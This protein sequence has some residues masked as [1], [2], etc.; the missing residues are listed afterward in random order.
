MIK[1]NVPSWVRSWLSEICV[2]LPVS[3]AVSLLLASTSWAVV[4]N[5]GDLVVTATNDE[6]GDVTMDGELDILSGKIYLG[7]LE[8]VGGDPGIEITYSD[9]IGSPSTFT[10]QAKSSPNVWLWKQ[11]PNS[12][13]KQ[14]SLDDSNTLRLFTGGAGDEVPGVTISPSTGILL[15]GAD[16]GITLHDSTQIHS[17][18]SLRQSAL[19]ATPES[20]PVV[21]VGSDGLTFAGGGALNS[22]NVTYLQRLLTNLGYAGSRI[23]GV[24][25][26]ISVP[27]NVAIA[28]GTLDAVGNIYLCGNFSVPVPALGL[29]NPG[30]SDAFVAKLS[31][32]GALLWSRT[33]TGVGSDSARAVTV[34]A[35]GNVY[36]AGEY[37]SA[38]T[39]GTTTLTSAGLTDIF[40]AKYT[41]AGAFVWAVTAGGP[42][43]DTVAGLCADSAGDLGLTGTFTTAAAWGAAGSRTA[44]GADGYLAKLSAA[45]VFQWVRRFGGSSYENVVGIGT[46][47]SNSFTVGG[48]FSGSGSF[49]GTTLTPE[50]VSGRMYL[51]RVGSNG[52]SLWAKN[53]GGSVSQV[54]GLSVNPSGQVDLCGGFTGTLPFVIGGSNQV[55]YGPTNST[56]DGFVA[57]IGASGSAEWARIFGGVNSDAANY[58]ARDQSGGLI[59]GG[60]YYGPATFLGANFPAGG[61]NSYLARL[62][63]SGEPQSVH[64]VP[65]SGLASVGAKVMVIGTASS[66]TRI[67]EEVVSGPGSFA[68]VWDGSALSASSAIA[69]APF[70]WGTSVAEQPG[71]F[72]IG[73]NALARG[74]DSF[75]AG[76]SSA[77]GAS[78]VAL[79][80]GAAAAGV[81]A[82][83]LGNGAYASGASAIALGSSTKALG[84]NSFAA[85]SSTTALGSSSTA[86][87]A[88][89]SASG[90]ASLSTGS[91]T[92]ALGNNSATFGTS[93]TALSYLETVFGRYNELQTTPLPNASSWVATDNLFVIG[94]GSSAAAPA[95]A[96]TVKKDGNIGIGILNPLRKLEVNGDI[97]LSNSTGDKAIYTWAATDPYWK[98]G[99]SA[100][101]PFARALTTAHVQYASYGNTPSQGFALG[102]SGGE[103]GF[104]IRGLDHRAY[105]RGSLTVGPPQIP[106]D[107]MGAG[108]PGAIQFTSAEANDYAFI[109][110]TRL[111]PDS[112]SLD[113]VTGDNFENFRFITGDSVVMQIAGSN[114]GIGTAA[115]AVGAKLHVAGDAKFDGVIR[116]NG[117]AGDIPMFQ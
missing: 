24:D 30:S 64:A 7:R 81:S 79:G 11:G 68:Y 16:V 111:G 103:A 39:A 94:N 22:G 112:I 29:A 38:A 43:N 46:D 15:N 88:S 48:N 12:G 37:S 27:Q 76:S 97:V 114:V 69:D 45:G 42:N 28:R 54:D 96:F 35:S 3:L 80:S 67:G 106:A 73:R 72:A 92:K 75:A 101:P 40:V 17:A 66:N 95:N 23:V 26:S 51:F 55:L 62:S 13:V 21:S 8:G 116:T 14:M 1:T 100:N 58:I 93:T 36:A 61:A 104:E 25:T 6:Q 49:E 71:S 109:K 74:V 65:V 20:D 10:L 110:N 84:S 113:F 32:T 18:R 90:S 34:D 107:Y 98:I 105:L 53:Y 9:P 59:L 60:Y 78:S 50:S 102:A 52:T 4:P 89:T 83:A 115:P 77:T 108:G 57:R 33:I 99:M 5:A 47:G 41:A 63:A 31:P 2:S 56:W 82:L 44:T 86:L 117:P 91:S 87:G 19:Y 85:G 70:S